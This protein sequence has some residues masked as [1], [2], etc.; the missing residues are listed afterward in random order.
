MHDSDGKQIYV[1]CWRVIDPTVRIHGI[2][3]NPPVGSWFVSPALADR[4]EADSALV[5]RYPNA[6]RIRTRGVA[7]PDELL[8]YRFVE[9]DIVLSEQLSKQVSNWVGDGTEALVLFPIA[10]AA[11]ALIGIPGLGLLAAAM[12]PYA[13]LFEHRLALLNALGTSSLMQ[14]G[15]R[16]NQNLWMADLS[17]GAAYLP[18]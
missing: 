10:L 2:G 7:H 13:I 18:V 5:E 3:P 9:P 16:Y 8:A 1:Y 4:M 6:Q 11:L 15:V 17:L 14:R 12:A